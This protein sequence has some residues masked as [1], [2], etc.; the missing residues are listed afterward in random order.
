MAYFSG[1]LLGID[2]SAYLH[3]LL[4]VA[5]VPLCMDLFNSKSVE[6]AKLKSFS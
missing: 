5:C 6:H 2:I 3:G 4:P 1:L